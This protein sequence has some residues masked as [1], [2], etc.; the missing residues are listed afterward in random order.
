MTLSLDLVSIPE[1]GGVSTVTATLSGPSS[2]PV[3]V[4]AVPDVP[5]T[6]ADF[7][8][9]GATLTIATG[10]TSSTEEVTSTAA[11]NTVDAPAKT[12]GDR[13]RRERRVG[14][15][16][17]DA[18]DHRRRRRHAGGDA[19]AL[20]YLDPRGRRAEHGDGVVERPVERG[21]EGDDR[22]D[23]GLARGLGGFPDQG[24]HGP[25]DRGGPDGEFGDGVT[26]TAVD[27]TQDAPD[28]TVTVTASVTGGNGVAPPEAET[29][30]IEDNDG[31]PTVTLKLAPASIGENGG[32]STV[33]ASLT[34]A[35]SERVT[36]TV[37]TSPTA[38][39]VETDYTLT[40]TTLTIDPGRTESTG[41]VT[42]AGVNNA[43]HAPDKTVEV[44]ASVTGGRGV[45]TPATQTLTI[46]DDERMPTVSLELT[47]PVIEE[48]EMSEARA[49]LSGPSSEPVKVNVDALPA[50]HN[51]CGTGRPGPAARR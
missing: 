23:G 26:I 19:G 6:E 39:A 37:S 47:P 36:V 51:P 1:D 7:T 20:P 42:I 27:N 28:K 22:G 15:G 49:F 17:P 12:V 44:T 18:D 8:L 48:G 10:Q 29:L 43:I 9:T 46:E 5:A 32:V 38:P 13:E 16:P 24:E 14:A 33:T 11:D 35:S 30:T 31:T 41:T 25:D 45:T 34:A 50:L 4:Q 21:G 3:T 40:G 2:A